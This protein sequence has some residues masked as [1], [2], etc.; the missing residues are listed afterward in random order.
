MGA[1]LYCGSRLIG[2][3]IGRYSNLTFDSYLE[4]GTS[5]P[6]I[7]H[8]V[9]LKLEHYGDWITDVLLDESVVQMRLARLQPSQAPSTLHHIDLV[10]MCVL[11]CMPRILKHFQ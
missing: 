5:S 6:G 10:Y 7:Y 11:L 3:Y 8:H 4:P 9:F 2:M 1:P